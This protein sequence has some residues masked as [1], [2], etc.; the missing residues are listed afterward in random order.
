[1]VFRYRVHPLH[2]QLSNRI[3]SLSDM[4]LL[5]TDGETLEL[6]Y[7]PDLSSAP[8][9]AVL[10]HT[11]LGDSQEVLFEHVRS[12]IYP[13]RCAKG[14]E[15]VMNCRRQAKEDGYNYVWID[16]C[17]IDK[18]SS[19]ELSEAIN[20]MF[21]IYEGAGLCYAHLADVDNADLPKLPESAFRESRWFKRG[22][23]LQELIAPRKVLFFTSTWEKIQDKESLSDVIEEITGIN[24]SILQGYSTPPQASIVERMSW[25]ADRR[26]T[27]LEDEA[28]SLMGLF[29]VNMPTVYGEGHEHAFE[30]LQHEIITLAP[31][32]HDILAWHGSDLLPAYHSILAPSVQ[33]FCSDGRDIVNISRRV[34]NLAWGL[35]DEMLGLRRTSF[36]LVAKL[37]IFELELRSTQTDAKNLVC[38]IMVIACKAVDVTG[39]HQHTVGI[40]LTRVSNI[41]N[42]IYTRSGNTSLVDVD[43]LLQLK[44]PWSLRTITLADR[45]QRLGNHR[46]RPRN[47]YEWNLDKCGGIII[48]RRHANFSVI[49]PPETP[50]KHWSAY[51]LTD[52]IE[53]VCICS[54]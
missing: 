52:G 30:R 14:L 40:P 47:P 10:S 20:S 13:L 54:K 9:Y 15:K 51:H 37:P 44:F 1:M 38:A 7:I 33:H 23:T 19:A 39:A 24:S 50:D 3:Q 26:T 49:S 17:C 32:T 53:E 31:F 2:F 43:Y 8:R 27:R 18:S 6:K 28:Y 5:K 34:F 42:D 21:E 16:T 45:T 35:G 46:T 11:W 25:A 41:E 22:W 29:G 4:Y 12:G 36:G 48:N